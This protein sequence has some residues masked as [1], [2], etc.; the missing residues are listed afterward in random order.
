MRYEELINQRDFRIA[1]LQE[2]DIKAAA[3]NDG[4]PETWTKDRWPE[5]RA[6]C[7]KHGCLVLADAHAEIHEFDLFK[8]LV[9]GWS[10]AKGA[11]QTAIVIRKELADIEAVI[12]MI[13][14]NAAD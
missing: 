12:G 4:W 7:R 3:P 6:I 14:R 11:E 9:G 13:E 2:L 10:P 5:F 1:W 8:I